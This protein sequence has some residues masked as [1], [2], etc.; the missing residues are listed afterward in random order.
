MCLHYLPS[1]DSYC[2]GF[3]SQSELTL[4]MPGLQGWPGLSGLLGLPWLSY[5]S[6]YG[7]Q[8]AGVCGIVGSTGFPVVVVRISLLTGLPNRRGYYWDCRVYWVFR[9]CWDCRGSRDCRD[10]WVDGVAKLPG[11][12]N[13]RVLVVPRVGVARF[14]GVE[15]YAMGTRDNGAIRVIRIRPI[16][17]WGKAHSI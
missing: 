17:N 13:H 8:I 10:Y 15:G 1:R 4:W 9:G 11:V 7:W 16:E 3:W 12:P 14:A 2:M 5:L 6:R